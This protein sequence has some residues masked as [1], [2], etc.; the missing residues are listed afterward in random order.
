MS[1]VVSLRLPDETARRLKLVAKRA[2]RSVNQVG[3]ASIE[4]WLRMNEFAGI[5]FR[6]SGPYRYAGLKHGPKVWSVIRVARLYDMDMRQTT[7]HFELP[8]EMIQ[9]AFDYYAA[10]PGDIDAIIEE[11]ESITFEDLK[12]DFPN[13]EVGP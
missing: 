12:R 8:K 3:A 10:Y 6:T 13:I 11:E 5:E 7:D 1:Q 9:T 2:K 4:E